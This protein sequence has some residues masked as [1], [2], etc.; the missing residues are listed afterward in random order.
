MIYPK[1]PIIMTLCFV[2]AAL[3]F[4][5]LLKE[6]SLESGQFSALLGWIVAGLMAWFG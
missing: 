5:Q 3:A 6:D 1:R 4:A 2:N